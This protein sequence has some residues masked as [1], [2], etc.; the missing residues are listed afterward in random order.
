M[1]NTNKKANL[2]SKVKTNSLGLGIVQTE[3]VIVDN[4]ESVVNSTGGAVLTEKLIEKGENS[5]IELISEMSFVE[6]D[7]WS[8]T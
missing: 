8:N 4:I 1:K 2:E 3:K 7:V 6:L 5:P